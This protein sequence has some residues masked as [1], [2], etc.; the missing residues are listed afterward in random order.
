M[1]KMIKNNKITESCCVLHYLR[2][3]MVGV[4]GK[5]GFTGIECV[6]GDKGLCCSQLSALPI[7]TRHRYWTGKQVS[8]HIDFQV[9]VWSMKKNIL[10]IRIWMYRDESCSKNQWTIDVM[11]SSLSNSSDE[12]SSGCRSL[13]NSPFLISGIVR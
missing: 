12:M 4:V 7:N 5:S 10:I 13:Y 3:K 2:G 6:T 11:T 9:F 1:Y 8:G